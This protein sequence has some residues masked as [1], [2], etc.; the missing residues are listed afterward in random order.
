MNPGILVTTDG[1]L[2]HVVGIGQAANAQGHEGEIFAISE[3]IRLPEFH[4]F[5]QL[6]QSGFILPMD[7]VIT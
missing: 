4:R 1:H 2:D 3:G 6:C 5:I 7:A